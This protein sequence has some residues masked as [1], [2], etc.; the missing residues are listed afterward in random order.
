MAT[1]ATMEPPRP[2]RWLADGDGAIALK[3]CGGK[4]AAADHAM[5]TAW[6]WENRP[7]WQTVA[8][9]G[10]LRTIRFRIT[11]RGVYLLTLDGFSGAECRYRLIRSIGATPDNSRLTKTWRTSP[12][13]VG[14]CTFPGRQRWTNDFGAGH[15]AGMTPDEA[16]RLDTELVARAGFGLARPDVPGTGE[17][18]GAAWIDAN[19]MDAFM[20]DYAARGMGVLLQIGAPTPVMAK[21]RSA[22]DPLWRYPR[23]EA[24]YR[25]YV[26]ELMRRYAGG[27]DV[28]EIWN[29]PDNLDFWRGTPDEFIRQ[30]G[31]AAEEIKKAAPTA[32]TSNG[33]Y[34]FNKPEWT[35]ILIRGLKGAASLV[36]YHS[37]GDLAQLEK[38]FGDVVTLHKAAAYSAP[39]YINT[40]MGWAAWRL[41]QERSQAFTAMQKLLFC[42]ASGHEIS[43]LYASREIGGPRMRPKEPDWGYVDHLFCPR[44]AYGA[45]AAFLETFAGARFV[46]VAAREGGSRAYQFRAGGRTLVA[47]FGPDAGRRAVVT[48]SWRRAVLI[49]PMGNRTGSSGE[50]IEVTAGSYPVTLELETASS[51]S[52]AFQ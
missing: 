17:E 44:F 9:V 37:H 40:E 5:L 36:A 16:W 45:A 4:E 20:R 43:M 7:V 38:A 33:G 51:V 18:G 1:G 8:P 25:R 19:L 31:W 48:G 12:F 42:W 14:I 27:S 21:Y 15:P 6:D 50:R 35:P 34:C 49:D 3:V 11:G 23:D 26:A 30:H 22:T 41:D 2:F 47:L 52:V 46:R 32:V 39:R 24:P 13:R 28:V 10:E 29:E